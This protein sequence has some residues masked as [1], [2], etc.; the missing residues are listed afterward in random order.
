MKLSRPAQA[1][2]RW[3]WTRAVWSAFCSVSVGVSTIASGPVG[4]ARDWE[5]FVCGAFG[6]MAICETVLEIARRSAAARL[7]ELEMPEHVRRQIQSE[8]EAIHE[9][10]I[11]AVRARHPDMVFNDGDDSGVRH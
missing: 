1:V 11:A 4:W 6:G 8:M 2:L 9:Q 10:A 5:M 3:P 7:V